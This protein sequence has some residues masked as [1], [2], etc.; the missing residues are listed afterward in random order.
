MLRSTWVQHK[1]EPAGITTIRTLIE[2]RREVTAATVAIRPVSESPFDPLDHLVS[3]P[4]DIL[5]LH[6]K[7]AKHWGLLRVVPSASHCPVL[8]TAEVVSLFPTKSR[9]NYVGATTLTCDTEI[10]SPYTS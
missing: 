1:N 2:Y 6:K 4:L 10:G 9:N 7:S 8:P 5:F 3:S